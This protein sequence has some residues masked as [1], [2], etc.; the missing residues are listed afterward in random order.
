MA[1]PSRCEV[2]KVEARSF[3]G[4]APAYHHAEGIAKGSYPSGARPIEDDPRQHGDFRR[5]VVWPRPGFSI[6]WSV[7]RPPGRSY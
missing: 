3:G 5:K 7:P 6:Y 4:A 1:R 2:S